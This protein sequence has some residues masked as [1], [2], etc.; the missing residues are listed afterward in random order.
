MSVVMFVLFSVAL[1]CLDL[2]TYINIFFQTLFN[3]DP[4]L[5]NSESCLALLSE[6]KHI[7][8]LYNGLMTDA[9]PATTQ[10][11][12]YIYKTE[13]NGDIRH[14]FCYGLET[15]Q[16]KELRIEEATFTVPDPPGCHLTC[17][18]EKVCAGLAVAIFV[19]G[20]T[21]SSRWRA[22][23]VELSVLVLKSSLTKVESILF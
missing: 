17:Y 4:L 2:R 5:C 8:S 6:A 21:A 14:T 23:Y 15:D 13:E 7:Q 12:I 16:W 9:R 3:S 19:F 11:Y 10:S 1:Q 18:A 22:R 20:H